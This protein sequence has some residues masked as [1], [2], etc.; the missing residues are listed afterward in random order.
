[1]ISRGGLSPASAASLSWASCSARLASSRGLMMKPPTCPLRTRFSTFW[2]GPSS[3]SSPMIDCPISFFSGVGSSPLSSPPIRA[4]ASA[5]T[6]PTTSST[7]TPSAIACRRR[8]L[9][10]RS[11]WRSRRVPGTGTTA[12]VWGSSRSRRRSPVPLS[13]SEDEDRLRP[14]PSLGS[15]RLP[16]LGRSRSRR[17]I[18]LRSTVSGSRISS[19]GIGASSSDESSSYA[20]PSELGGSSAGGSTA[21][22]SPVPSR[23]ASRWRLAPK[24]KSRSSGSSNGGRPSIRSAF[25]APGGLRLAACG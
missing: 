7:I 19:S 12:G 1:M 21:A 5:T 4:E 20:G 10:G 3:P 13:S 6:P 22:R 15:R 16:L 14:N 8:T 9:A 25:L 18:A 17:A 23:L 2:S 11:R 24:S